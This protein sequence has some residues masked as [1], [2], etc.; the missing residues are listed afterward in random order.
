MKIYK[1]SKPKTRIGILLFILLTSGNSFAG[2]KEYSYPKGKFSIQFPT[3]PTIKEDGAYTMVTSVNGT[4]AYQ[5][6]YLSEDYD[7]AASSERMYTQSFGMYGSIEGNVEEISS[8]GLNGRKAKVKNGASIYNV[9]VWQTA[10]RN[11]TLCVGKTIGKVSEETQ[12]EFFSTFKVN[13]NQ[14]STVASTTATNNSNENGTFD[15]YEYLKKKTFPFIANQDEIGDWQYPSIDKLMDHIKIDYVDLKSKIDQYGESAFQNSNAGKNALKYI[16]TDLPT[17]YPIVPQIVDKYLKVYEDKQAAEKAG[18]DFA[19]GMVDGEP[20]LKFLK[21]LIEFTDDLY[22]ISKDAGI[23]A[24]NEKVRARYNKAVSEVDFINSTV[25]A[26]RLDELVLYS[27]SPKIGEEK[28]SDEQKVLGWGKGETMFAYWPKNFKSSKNDVKLKFRIDGGAFFY[29]ELYF[30]NETRKE[31]FKTR[32]HLR[33]DFFPDPEQLDYKTLYEYDGHINFLSYFIDQSNGMHKLE[34]AIEAGNYTM[35]KTI[36]VLVDD[37]SKKEMEKLKQALILKKIESTVLP[38]CEDGSGI[39]A[40]KDYFTTNGFGTLLKYVQTDPVTEMK[41]GKWP[42]PVIGHSSGGW[43]IVK[44]SDGSLEIIRI[45]VSRKLNGQNWM[46]SISP[47]PSK[48]DMVGNKT[49]NS[50]I[51]NHGYKMNVDNAGKC[52]YWEWE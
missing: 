41:D 5:V 7:I 36:E 3:E 27:G 37:N 39:I 10:T 22:A 20:Q 45:G 32:G 19:K 23:K 52:F 26:K 49:Y 47:L 6:V 8:N 35:E 46:A 14:S 13:G 15:S 16:N 50:A 29:Q 1:K 42:Y 17:L 43:G 38:I 28:E 9:I 30:D 4:T 25:H 51:G 2:W 11:W 33:F 21:V 31:Q 34:F 44:Q 40:N 24:S 48:Y 18:D 12:N